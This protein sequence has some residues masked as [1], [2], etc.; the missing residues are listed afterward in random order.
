MADSGAVTMPADND[1]IECI[2][3]MASVDWKTLA[4]NGN[5]DIQVLIYASGVDA[6]WP[7]TGHW[8]VI[9]KFVIGDDGVFYRVPPAPYITVRAQGPTGSSCRVT[10]T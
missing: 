10:V 6:T 9:K 2:A 3:P 1:T 5:R 7:G 8:S 4:C